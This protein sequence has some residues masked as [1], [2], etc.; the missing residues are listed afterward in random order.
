MFVHFSIIFLFSFCQ[1]IYPKLNIT[2][3]VEANDP[4]EFKNWCSPGSSQCDYER[5][6]VPYRC[7]GKNLLYM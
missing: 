3:I 1:K 4:V 2:N 6:V 5:K 7:L